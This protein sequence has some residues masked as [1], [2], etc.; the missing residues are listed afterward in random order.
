MDLSKILDVTP[1]PAIKLQ[2][3][4]IG[5]T[6]STN[7]N[8][9]EDDYCLPTPMAD[10]QKELT[11]DIVS[12]HYSDI[13]KYFETNNR[14][15]LLLIDSLQKLYL[16]IQLISSHPYLLIDHFMPKSLAAKDIPM[17]LI[18]T[19]GK[20]K[21]LKNVLDI[22]SG[23]LDFRKLLKS[24]L[25]NHAKFGKQGKLS[26]KASNSTET[27]NKKINQIIVSNVKKRFIN[28]ITVPSNKNILLISREGRTLD[29]IESL[30]LGLKMPYVKYSGSNIK[31]NNKDKVTTAQDIDIKKKLGSYL[32]N[33]NS[34]LK[35]YLNNNNFNLFPLY[36]VTVHLLS[37]KDLE[38]KMK[39]L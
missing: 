20:F 15:D 37:S 12:L 38:E 29:L 8:N 19:S 13:L 36:N 32:I 30:M 21:M 27:S 22:Y 33:L 25:H 16:N 24:E 11:D 7:Y 31:N 39:M 3:S 2:E 26:S 1:E 10:F 35:N 4:L 34:H 5:V 6:D 18:Q 23:V 28:E 14:D 9:E 17:K